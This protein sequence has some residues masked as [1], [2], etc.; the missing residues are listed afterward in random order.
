MRVLT[1][2]FKVAQAKPDQRFAFF[3]RST[4]ASDREDWDFLCYLAT[5][6][7]GICISITR[8]QITLANGTIIRYFPANQPDAMRGQAFD[9]VLVD[10]SVDARTRAAILGLTSRY[11]R[12]ETVGIPQPRFGLI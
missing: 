9:C 8:N 10:S 6:P 1:G 7:A 12:T 2:F 5:H 11:T 3:G 4:K